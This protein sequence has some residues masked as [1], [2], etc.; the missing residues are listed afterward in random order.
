MPSNPIPEPS[1]G[2]QRQ[3]GKSSACIHSDR[4]E[5]P[6]Y[7][8]GESTRDSFP[9]PHQGAAR[10]P[11]LWKLHLEPTY[12]VHGAPPRPEAYHEGS[13]STELLLTSLSNPKLALNLKQT[14]DPWISWQ[15]AGVTHWHL[16]VYT[17]GGRKEEKMVEL[18]RPPWRK[19]TP[20]T[21]ARDTN[22]L[23]FMICLPWIVSLMACE[24]D[25]LALRLTSM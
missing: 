19:E 10:G 21:F 6:G 7:L 25:L 13:Y 9:A 8:Q 15:W 22:G 23:G 16:A 1:H 11:G 3:R 2:R 17:V 5:Q 4:W 20:E 18:L 24:L 14:M 12:P